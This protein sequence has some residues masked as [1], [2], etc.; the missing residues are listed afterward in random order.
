MKPGKAITFPRPRCLLVPVIT[1]TW[2]EEHA[3]FEDGK[4]F[5]V[6]LSL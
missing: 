1:G 2:K 5:E 6:R 3:I 4:E